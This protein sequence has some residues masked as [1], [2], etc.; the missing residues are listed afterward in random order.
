MKL[1]YNYPVARKARTYSEARKAG[2]ASS[3]AENRPKHFW[4]PE[5]LRG[6]ISYYSFLHLLLYINS[7]LKFDRFFSI[8]SFCKTQ[9]IVLKNYRSFGMLEQFFRQ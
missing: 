2:K 1:T 7:F 6:K 9:V 5:E 4:L 8:K 3:R